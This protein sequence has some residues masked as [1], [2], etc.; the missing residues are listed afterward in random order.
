MPPSQM[1]AFFL[2]RLLALFV[3][4]CPAIGQAAP[5][6]AQGKAQIVL[7]GSIT[8]LG[9]LYFG[10]LTVTTA[11]TAVVDSNTDTVTTTGGVVFVG[12]TPHA[13]RFEA[14]SPSKNI[15]KISLP[16]KAV[17]LI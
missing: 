4:L 11:G 10:K 15:V 12:G 16:K 7:G 2:R 17:T 1:G 14:V 8:N 6:P 9:E 13:A 3:L 5:A